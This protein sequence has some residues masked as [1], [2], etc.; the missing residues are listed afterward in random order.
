VLT[1]LWAVIAL[2]AVLMLSNNIANV[3]DGR[4]LHAH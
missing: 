1:L 3:I 2:V 4:P